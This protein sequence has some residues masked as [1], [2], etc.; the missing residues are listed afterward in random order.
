M[1]LVEWHKNCLKQYEMES[2]G[3]DT[4]IEYKLLAGVN[5]ALNGNALDINGDGAGS[6]LFGGASYCSILVEEILP[7]S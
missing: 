1:K 4:A 5:S 6:R 3:A 2:P 7:V